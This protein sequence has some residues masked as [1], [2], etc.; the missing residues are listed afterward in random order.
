MVGRFCLGSSVSSGGGEWVIFRNNELFLGISS[1]FEGFEGIG[2]QASVC[3]YSINVVAY[4]HTLLM[5]VK[6]DSTEWLN[7]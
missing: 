5:C 4:A 1:C 7:A 6:D 3:P 2:V